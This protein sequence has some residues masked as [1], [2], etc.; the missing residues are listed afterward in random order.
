[1]NYTKNITF[2]ILLVS[3]F[4]CKTIKVE[5]DW[6]SDDFQQIKTKTILVAAKSQNIKTRKAYESAIAKNLQDNGIKAVLANEKFPNLQDKKRSD[7][8]KEKLLTAF[9]KEGIQGILVT[10]LKNT[11]V[12]TNKNERPKIQDIPIDYSRRGFFTFYGYDEL[13]DLPAVPPQGYEKRSFPE[14]ESTVYILE[15]TLYDISLE[16]EK[17][18]VSVQ[19]V[20][21][22]DPT[23]GNQV[24][25]KFSKLITKQFKK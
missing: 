23:S 4:G 21:V 18:L 3:V 7:V 14:L 6:Q 19:T 25:Q 15:A 16:K 5:K 20:E 24:L 10:S 1:M 22:T 8:E 2:F 17:Q 9:K 12:R 11:I 13:R